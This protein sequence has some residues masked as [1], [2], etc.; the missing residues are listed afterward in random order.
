VPT[1]TSGQL[2]N[3]IA[4][5]GDGKVF[6]KPDMV[7]INV[8]ASE[9]ANTTKDAMAKVN[10]KINQVMDIL[11]TNN[12]PEKDVQTSNISLSPEYD[13]STTP[14]YLKGQRA[15]EGL[16]I[17][18]KKIDPTAEKVSAIIDAVS[19]IN[20]IELGGITFDI[21]DKTPFYTQAREL[22]FQKAKQKADELAK[23]GGVELLKPVSISDTS[24]NYYSPVYSNAYM[25]NAT[26]SA[27]SAGSQIATG[28]LEVDITVN[29][30]WGIK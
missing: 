14:K 19:A 22:A 2:T 23:L 13:W 30:M 24:V 17:N 4:V 7:I 16:T 27:D 12:I 9:L 8:T 26:K 3:T 29:V 11:K 10:D 28:Q 1:T 21:E 20:N 15:T 5:N 18:I 25:M 6:A